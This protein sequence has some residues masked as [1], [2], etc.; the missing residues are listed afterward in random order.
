[1]LLGAGYGSYMMLLDPLRVCSGMALPRIAFDKWE[2]EGTLQHWDAPVVTSALPFIA[3]MCA[4][5]FI[6]Q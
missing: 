3:F 4:I 5:A 1:M 6:G 2:G